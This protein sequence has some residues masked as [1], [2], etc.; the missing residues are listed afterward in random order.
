MKSTSGKS[1]NSLSRAEFDSPDLEATI[2]PH[3]ME[4]TDSVW[5]EER[6]GDSVYRHPLTGA[7]FTIGRA[8][9]CDLVLESEGRFVSREHAKI[10][11]AQGRCWIIDLSMNGTWVNGERLT[12]RKR[13]ELQPG[14]TSSIEDQ[15]FTFRAARATDR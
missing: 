6:K 3:H 13:R 7:E 1:P 2:G 12:R 5:L 9:H 11:A 15:E 14:D 10:V 8:T 4:Q